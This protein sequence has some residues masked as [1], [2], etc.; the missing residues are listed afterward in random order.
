MVPISAPTKV[1][2][3]PSRNDIFVSVSSTWYA[4][5][6]NPALAGTAYQYA[7]ETQLVS[8]AFSFVLPF[9]DTEVFQA[10]A[11]TVKW[12]IDLGP[13]GVWTGLLP[14]SVGSTATLKTLATANGWVAITPGFAAGT[15]RVA[16]PMVG[17]K[18]GV[19]TVFTVRGAE[20]YLRAVPGE[21]IA[22]YL[23]GCRLIEGTDFTASESGGSGTGYDTITIILA[24]S[25]PTASD[26][27]VCDY[28]VA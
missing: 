12:V 11:A 26:T 1:Y 24:A 23:G 7:V 21:N 27:L 16:E 20:K 14:S 2:A 6:I 13:G 9:T 28:V 10:S 22:P 19:N 15:R 18:N 4:W 25:I 17:G 5:A 3:Y 8:S